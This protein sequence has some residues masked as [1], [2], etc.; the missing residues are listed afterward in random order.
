MIGPPSAAP[1]WTRLNFGLGSPVLL[2]KTSFAMSL[3]LVKA[4]NTSPWNSLVPDLVID[5]TMAAAVLLA[6]HALVEDRVLEVDAVDE[7][8]DRGRRRRAALEAAIGLAVIIFY[9]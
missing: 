7:H 8:V 4:P 6:G 9:A 5:V 2:S 1:Y 3:W